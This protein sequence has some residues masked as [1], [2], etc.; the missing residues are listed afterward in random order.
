MKPVAPFEATS[1]QAIARGFDRH[2]GE[3][4]E[5][6]SLATY[7]D[8]LAAYHLSPENK[9]LNADYFDIGATVR[10]HVFATEVMH[11]GKEAHDWENRDLRGA[12]SSPVEYQH[13]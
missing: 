8:V 11:I 13:S 1:E 10:R 2:T 6:Q 3:P 12:P 7:S 4:V 9:F 5:P